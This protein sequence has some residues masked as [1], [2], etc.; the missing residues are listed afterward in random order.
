MLTRRVTFFIEVYVFTVVWN[1]T[2]NLIKNESILV[3]I[4]GQTNRIVN[5]SNGTVP[6]KIN[7]SFAVNSSLSSQVLS[8]RMLGYDHAGNSNSTPLTSAFIVTVA[9]VTAPTIT[10]VYPTNRSNITA[11]SPSINFTVSD[12]SSVDCEIYLNY[13]VNVTGIDLNASSGTYRNTTAFEGLLDQK[14]NYSINCTDT[15]GNTART[16][17]ITFTIDRGS[18][19]IA[20]TAPANNSN[21]S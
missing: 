18:P 2:Y 8:F 10:I 21:V 15:S 6:Q 11:G 17:N 9:D 19:S 7:L 3:N 5:S 14:Y 16:G 1:G 13:T 12:V 20:L 4:S